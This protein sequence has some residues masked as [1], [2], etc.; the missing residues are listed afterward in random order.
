M[1]LSILAPTSIFSK[2]ADTAMRVPLRTH[3]P[4]TLPGM[5]STAGHCDQSSV[6]M[7]LP[8]TS[9]FTT[10]WRRRHAPDTRGAGGKL[11]IGCAISEA[12]DMARDLRAP[13]LGNERTRQSIAA[14]GKEGL[15]KAGWWV[16][17]LKRI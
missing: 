16:G 11:D 17:D 1:I 14:S 3:V 15:C 9:L 10:V 4:L 6:A 8:S 12:F 5:L 13:S 2:I 7:F